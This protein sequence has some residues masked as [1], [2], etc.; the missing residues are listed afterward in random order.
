M[1]LSVDVVASGALAARLPP[2]ERPG[3]ARMELPGG[4]SVADLL[5]VLGIEAGRP[6]LAILNG[7]VVAPDERA[8]ARLADGDTLSLAPPIRAG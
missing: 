6:L 8:S 3:R 7:A 5:A 2:G 4:S 1:P